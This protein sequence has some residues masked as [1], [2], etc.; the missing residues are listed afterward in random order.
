V[1]GGAALPYGYTLTISMSVAVVAHRLGALWTTLEA[2]RQLIYS[3]AAR[4]DAGDAD[5]LPAILAAKAAAADAAVTLANE[6]MTLGG[7]MAY[8]DNS[9]LARILRDARASHVMAPTTD[10]LKTWVGRALLKLPLI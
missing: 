3:A 10:I 5:A 1:V 2:T 9:R 4:G 6:A 7:G 8:R